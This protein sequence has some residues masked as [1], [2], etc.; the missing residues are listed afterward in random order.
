VVIRRIVFVFLTGLWIL[1]IF[2][3]SSEIGEVS[4]EKSLKVTQV[5]YNYAKDFDM[6]FVAKSSRIHYYVRKLGHVMEYFIL[7]LLILGLSYRTSFSIKYKYW[8]SWTL[9]TIISI[10]DEYYQ[11]SVYGR[12]GNLKDIFIDNIG[13]ISSLFFIY[14]FIMMKRLW[15]S[16]FK[17]SI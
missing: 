2:T 1:V 10:I 13:I 5:V 9:V 16:N 6:D 8:I 17:N 12:Y 11:K 14:I 3:L 7:T 15:N 4:R